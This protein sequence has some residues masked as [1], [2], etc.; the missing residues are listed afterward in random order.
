LKEDIVVMAD[1][2]YGEFAKESGE[3]SVLKLLRDYD[4]LIVVKTFSKAFGMAGVRVGY[5][6]TNSEI[7][8]LINKIRFPNSV[9]TIP[10]E[11]ANIALKNVEWMSSVIKK[12]VSERKRMAKELSA[13][14]EFRIFPSST[15]FLLIGVSEEL[16]AE[17][18]GLELLKRGLVIR[19]YS[20]QWMKNHLRIT[21]RSPEQND[22]LLE[23]LSEIM[24][25]S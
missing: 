1:E 19:F 13:F 20:N 2:A 6:I 25:E 14:P 7:M 18:I 5:I 15:N 24:L 10:V 4:N 23:N 17:D 22:R 21:I 12:L 8:N 16:N 9:G 3:E 11:I